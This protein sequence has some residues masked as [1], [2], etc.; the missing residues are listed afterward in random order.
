MNA[1]RR[2]LLGAALAVPALWV[3]GAGRRTWADELPATRELSLVNTHTGESLLTRYYEAG[4]YIPQAL[5]RFQHLLRDHRSGEVHPIDPQLFDVLYHAAERNDREPHFEVISG[6]RSP[7][8]N[9]KLRSHSHGVAEH[10]LHM[11]GKAIDVRLSGVSCAKL[12]DVALSMRSGGVGYYAKSNFVHL[13]TGRV[14]T[15]A[16]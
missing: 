3:A 13:D 4:Q 9:A 10:S 2:S 1:T 16:G 7:G 8:S 15:W 5:T 14:R 12:R 11:E 6:Y